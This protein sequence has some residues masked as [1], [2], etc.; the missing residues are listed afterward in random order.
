MGGTFAVRFPVDVD[1]GDDGWHFEGSYAGTD[2][3]SWTNYWSK[4]RALLMLVLS[5]VDE[6]DAPTRIR[7]GSHGYIRDVMVRRRDHPPASVVRATRRG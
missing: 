7:V 6:D 3:W 1:P 2:G 4:D 5:D